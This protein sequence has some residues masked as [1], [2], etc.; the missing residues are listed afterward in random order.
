MCHLLDSSIETSSITRRIVYFID[1]DHYDI[2][3][4]KEGLYL[5]RKGLIKKDKLVLLNKEFSY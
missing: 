2:S 3:P 4:T 5:G 1:W